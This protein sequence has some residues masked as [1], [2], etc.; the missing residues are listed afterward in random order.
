ML[1]KVVGKTLDETVTRVAAL[2][3][4]DEDEDDSE[5]GAIVRNFKQHMRRII[6]LW[7]ALYPT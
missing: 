7:T 3:D 6:R 1:G 5:F 4:V 2:E